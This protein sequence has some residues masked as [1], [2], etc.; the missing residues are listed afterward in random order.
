MQPPLSASERACVR[1]LVQLASVRLA[2]CGSQALA[3][4]T[5]ALAKLEYNDRAQES[6]R[7]LPHF[8]ALGVLHL[9]GFMSTNMSLGAVNVSLTL[10]FKSL[11]PFFTVVLSLFFFG[12]RPPASV[13]LTL[14]PI[15]AGVIVASATDLSFNW[16]GFLTAM[17]S[18]LAF[19]SRSVLS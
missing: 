3:N 13:L 5:W 9:G 18:N 10:T 7:V 17:G 6:Q 4:M 1:Q 11:E 2:D 15:M 12:T 14:V 16:Y 19:Q 8:Q